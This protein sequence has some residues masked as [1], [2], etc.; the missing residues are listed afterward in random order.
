MKKRDT[1][2]ED[3]SDYHY[4][5]VQIVRKRVAIIGCEKQI[6]KLKKEIALLEKDL[7]YVR[8]PSTSY[9]EE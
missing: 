2:Y 9:E 6:E 7:K 8:T 4:L 1:Y 3:Y 5:S